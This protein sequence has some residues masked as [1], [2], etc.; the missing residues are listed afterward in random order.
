ML[1]TSCQQSS[2]GTNDRNLAQCLSQYKPITPDPMPSDGLAST[3]ATGVTYA[4]PCAGLVGAGV[5]QWSAV[6]VAH[7]RTTIR[8]YFIG[9]RFADGCGLLRD[10]NVSET[11]TTLRIEL[12][13]GAN[14][15]VKT[16]ACPAAGQNYVTQVTLST[17][18]G[19]QKIEGHNNQGIVRY[20]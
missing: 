15:S 18:L 16:N 2:M 12:G 4:A 6:V 20:L 19:S 5:M 3:F 7:D 11:P 1:A 17:P 13:A 14:P 9:G 10:V 8:I